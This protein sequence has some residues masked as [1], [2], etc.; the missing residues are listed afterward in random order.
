R[1]GWTVKKTL[2]HIKQYG[3]KAETLNFV[4]IVDDNNKLIDDL[5]IGQLLMADEDTLIFSLLDHSFVSITSTEN[6]EEALKIFQKYEREAM[7]IITEHGS[8]VG[9]VTFDDILDKVEDRD[10]EDIQKFG[11]SEGLDLSYTNTNLLTMVR[12]RA[13]WLVILFV[14]EMLTASAMQHFESEIE[15]AVVLALFVPLI[16]SSGGN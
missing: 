12:K 13:G 9:I 15:V 6:L 2:E 10:T 1:P 14:G 5:R 11:G 7:P 16:I 4:Y 8:L 3:E